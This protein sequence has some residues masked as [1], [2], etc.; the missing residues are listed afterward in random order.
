M[1]RAR[2]VPALPTLSSLLRH[3]TYGC[4]RCGPMGNVQASWGA[5]H[6][7]RS[8]SA[9]VK[10]LRAR[11]RPAASAGMVPRCLRHRTHLIWASRQRRRRCARTCRVCGPHDPTATREQAA[12]SPWLW[13]FGADRGH[14]W[15]ASARRPRRRGRT[16]RRRPPPLV[17]PPSERGGAGPPIDAHEGRVLGL[18]PFVT[19]NQ[20]VP[21]QGCRKCQNSEPPVATLHRILT[22]VTTQ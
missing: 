15:R 17:I 21:E 8:P 1:P 7:C 12:S 20:R 13:H 14:R 16:R 10:R 9:P 11:T 19:R 6:S 3:R 22:I 18:S 4:G 5:P 2:L